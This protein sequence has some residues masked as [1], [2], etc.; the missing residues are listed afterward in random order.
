MLAD[1]D[2]S[3]LEPK[4]KPK[5]SQGYDCAMPVAAHCNLVARR[6]SRVISTSTCLYLDW[7]TNFDKNP[8]LNNK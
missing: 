1:P 6:K 8:K 5:P 2:R 7:L 4:P 3:K